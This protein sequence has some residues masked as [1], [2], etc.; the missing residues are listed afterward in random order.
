[1]GFLDEVST[2]AG[3]WAVFN[4]IRGPKE[5]LPMVDS[6]HNS[7]L[8]QRPYT[9]RSAEWLSILSQGG[10]PTSSAHAPTGAVPRP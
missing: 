9:R 4:Q 1:M 5:A 3:I 8:Q 10:D 7:P 2:P 6:H